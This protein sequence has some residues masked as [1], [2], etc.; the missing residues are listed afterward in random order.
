MEDKGSILIV[1]D[2]INLVKTMSFVLKRKGYAVSMATGGAE[3]I[4]MVQKRPFD[5][6]F[7]DIKMPVM[8]GV[9]TFKRM[10]MV[11]PK[12]AV[13]MMTAYAVEE[14]VQEA[15]EEGAYG[16]IYKPLDLERV[17]ALIERAMETKRG[18]L[19]MVVDDEPGT[20]VTLRNILTRQGY[21]VSIAHTGEEA[22][23]LSRER[24]YDIIF[25][26]MKLPAMNGLETYL[27]LKE[28]NPEVVAIMMTGYFEE[29]SELVENAIS[30][31]AYACLH[32][33]LDIAQVLKLTD[34]IWERKKEGGAKKE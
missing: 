13:V 32:K 7:M 26:D 31:N 24:V 34:E 6:V 21:D 15:L 12:A 17:H 11:R 2:N 5:M 8:D 28:I 19:I 16:I 1:D 9:Q 10:K 29:L 30:N 23:S 14:L 33:P 18:A 20:Y 27:A 4:E 22:I 3:A 25:I